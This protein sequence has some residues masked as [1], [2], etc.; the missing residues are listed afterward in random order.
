MAQTRIQ[1][2]PRGD[3]STVDLDFGAHP[4]L[5]EFAGSMR[6]AAKQTISR[7]GK[8][9]TRIFDSYFLYNVTADHIGPTIDAGIFEEVHA[10]T[11]EAQAGTVFSFALDSDDTVDTTFGAE[12]IGTAVLD[13]VGSTTGLAVGDWL[14]LEDAVDPT[15]WQRAEIL[16]VDSGTALTLTRNLRRSFA[17]S[18]VLRHAEFFPTCQVV[19]EI[20][21]AERKAGSGSGQMWDLR[22]AFRTVR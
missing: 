13:P 6:A 1:W 21:F 9:V 17:A 2:T 12:A 22:F 10:W 14:F 11:A 8:T 3:V 4:V 7:G 5:V 20:K 19:G 15:K 16:T 18:S